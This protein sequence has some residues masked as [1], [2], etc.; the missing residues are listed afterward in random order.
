MNPWR[1]VW[2]VGDVHGERSKLVA[3]LREAELLD[4]H[5]Q[6]SGG[7][8]IL[9]CLGDYTDRG[10][11]GTGVMELIMRLEREA[12]D[13][14]GRVSALLGNHDL[15]LLAAWQF[16]DTWRDHRGRSFLERWSQNG[17]QSRDLERFHP[18]LVTWLS[19]RPVIV[20]LDPYLFMHADTE[21]YL[22]HGRSLRD[23]N[24]AFWNALASPDPQRWDELLRVLSGRD[25]FRSEEGPA[26][27]QQVLDAYQ[28]QCVVHGHTPIAVTL[29]VPA[30]HVRGPLAYAHDACLNVDGAMAYHP[31]AG[32]IV[33][34]NPEG[35]ER[36]IPYRTP[37]HSVPRE[38]LA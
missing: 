6:W 24:H 35:V 17:G 15:L 4:A 5:E 3:L 1:P 38:A 19:R 29:N 13:A 32:F 27:L 7:D 33:R 9:V 2:V 23:V 37:L 26:R 28:G 14:D 10:P 16:G 20:R 18:A 34:L 22:H 30:S 25:A 31:D 21:R 8:S 11:D 12:R 36:V